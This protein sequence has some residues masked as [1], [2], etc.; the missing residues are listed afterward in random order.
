[1]LLP[2]T[3]N[4]PVWFVFSLSRWSNNIG[5]TKAWNL[6]SRWHISVN[7][8]S[9]SLRMI[10]GKWLN[11]CWIIERADMSVCLWLQPDFSLLRVHIRIN[12][13]KVGKD[14]QAHP[15]PVLPPERQGLLSK[16]SSYMPWTEHC[17]EPQRNA[18]VGLF[19]LMFCSH[20][21]RMNNSCM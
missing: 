20:N 6:K 10:I 14:S 11:I 12:G 8:P 16:H 17:V 9:G 18:N 15:V 3:L 5:F 7:W 21:A 19:F 1:M 2:Q 13:C 4:D